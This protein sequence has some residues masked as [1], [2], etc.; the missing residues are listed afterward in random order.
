MKAQ[1][2]EFLR[3]YFPIHGVRALRS[4]IESPPPV[5]EGDCGNLAYGAKNPGVI[6]SRIFAR[7]QWGLTLGRCPNDV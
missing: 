3:V 6:T 1:N 2:S 7:S 5:E 4:R